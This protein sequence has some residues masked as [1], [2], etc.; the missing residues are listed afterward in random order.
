M[1]KKLLVLLGIIS[2]AAYV[3][4]RVKDANDERELWQEATG[5]PDLR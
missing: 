1:W 4:K 3:A 2:A 5:A